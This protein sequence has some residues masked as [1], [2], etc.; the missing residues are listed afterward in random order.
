MDNMRLSEIFIF[1]KLAQKANAST[2]IV[3]TLSGI[4]TFANCL[5]PLKAFLP[6]EVSPLGKFILLFQQLM[7]DK[8]FATTLSN[9]ISEKIINASNGVIGTT[10]K[11][12]LSEQ[13]AQALQN[14]GGDVLATAIGIALKTV[15]GNLIASIAATSISKAVLAVIMKIWS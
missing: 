13:L 9:E 8:I 14:A 5:Q 1:S 4:M 15:V 3:V 7:K 11:R 2:S 12:Q 10:L 6:M